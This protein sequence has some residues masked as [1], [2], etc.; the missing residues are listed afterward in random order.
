MHQDTAWEAPLIS[1]G[2]PPEQKSY[3]EMSFASVKKRPDTY[4]DVTVLTSEAK[5]IFLVLITVLSFHSRQSR[6]IRT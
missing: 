6:I 4:Q 3:Q 1:M 2:C 5:R